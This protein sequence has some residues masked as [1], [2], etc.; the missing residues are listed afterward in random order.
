[1][2]QRLDELVKNLGSVF[3]NLVLFKKERAGSLIGKLEALGPLAVLKRGFSVSLKIPDM[4]VISSVRS[5]KRGEDVQ[6]R[7]Q[8]GFFISRV[9]EV[10]NDG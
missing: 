4:K 3:Q 8:D 5:L 6:T 9:T 1:L 10:K 2:F 7:V